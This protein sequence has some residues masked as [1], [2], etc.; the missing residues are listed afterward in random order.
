MNDCIVICEN[1]VQRVFKCPWYYVICQYEDEWICARFDE[2][3]A[4][5][6]MLCSDGLD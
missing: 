2:K 1:N 3:S 5:E 6:T 4:S